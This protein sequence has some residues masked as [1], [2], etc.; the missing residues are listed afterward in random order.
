M[1][2]EPVRDGRPA[3]KP[4]LRVLAGEQVWPPPL[5]LM[6]QAGRYLPEYRE[7][8]AEAGDFITLCTT[9]ELAAEVTL[10]ADP[11][12]RLRRGDPVLRH[13]DGALGHGPAA[14]LRRGRGAAAGAGARRR[15]DRRAPSPRAWRSGR[16]PSW[17]RCG[18][19]G[20]RW[21]PHAPRT[22]L[23]GFA[24]SPF[25][26]ACYMVEGHGSRDFAATRAMAHADPALFGR[27][28]RDAGRG[29]GRLPRSP[30]PRPAPRR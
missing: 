16:R 6:R 5:W 21:T 14:P 1:T 13:P 12:L 3:A 22:A 8:R 17:R 11:P 23:I 10:A 15:G 18:W 27:L 19:C 7:V 20:R 29:D 9:P 28:I 2:S 30:R 26:V 25:T 4:L 24:G